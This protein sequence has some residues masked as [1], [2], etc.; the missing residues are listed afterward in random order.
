MQTMSTLWM[1][2]SHRDQIL[3][4]PPEAVLLASSPETP[5]EIWLLG[6]NVLAVQGMCPSICAIACHISF[7]T[8]AEYFHTPQNVNL[9]L[10]QLKLQCW[11]VSTTHIN[12]VKQA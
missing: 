9:G 12:V 4:L 6:G 8:Q 5:Y 7:R 11:C 2:C 10:I 1:C 3:E